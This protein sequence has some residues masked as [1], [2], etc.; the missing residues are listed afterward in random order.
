[1]RERVTTIDEAI[2]AH[3]READASRGNALDMGLSVSAAAVGLGAL[4]FT[5]ING[6]GPLPGTG[7]LVAMLVC[8][9]AAGAAALAV[10]RD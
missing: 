1:M 10:R 5:T 3:E 9:A 4:A 7:A 2:D 8:W 6:D